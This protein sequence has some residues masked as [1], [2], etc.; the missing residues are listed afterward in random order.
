MQRF[1]DEEERFADNRS[2]QAKDRGEARALA[3]DISFGVAAAA[4]V[5]ALIVW[6]ATDDEQAQPGEGSPDAAATI[7]VGASGAGAA[8]Q[9]N[10]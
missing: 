8:L 4:A 3:A 1:R 7:D 5:A 6:L 9:V 2:Q 10:F